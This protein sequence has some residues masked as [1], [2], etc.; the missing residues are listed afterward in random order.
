MYDYNNGRF[1][2]VDPFIQDPGSTQ[3]LNPYT[4]I[5]NNPLSG[6]DP[7]GYF[8]ELLNEAVFGGSDVVQTNPSEVGADIANRIKTSTAVVAATTTIG[9]IIKADEVSDYIFPLKGLA[10]K[11]VKETFKFAIKNGKEI[12]ET[13]AKKVKNISEKGVGS[14]VL[15]Y[16]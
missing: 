14:L 1:L 10:K 8:S 6:V 4:Y 11:G 13:V 2:S 9:V 3:S 7:T 12:A 15:L 16:F 5:F